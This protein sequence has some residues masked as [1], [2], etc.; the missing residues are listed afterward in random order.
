MS[1][2]VSAEHAAGIGELLDAV[3][4][5]VPTVVEEAAETSA[6][7]PRRDHWSARMSASHR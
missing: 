2:P 7:D 5:L 6:R 4:D 3:I 1:C